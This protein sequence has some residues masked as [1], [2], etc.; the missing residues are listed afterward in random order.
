MAGVGVMFAE[1]IQLLLLALPV[2]WAAWTVTKEEI[3]RELREYCSSRTKI[4]ATVFQRKFYYVWTCEYC[5]SHCVAVLVLA[6]TQF[7]L[8]YDDWRGY[9][10]SGPALVFVANVYM[11]LYSRLRVD[12]RKERATADLVE[13]SPR[14]DIKLSPSESLIKRSS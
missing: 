14:P 5:F 6:L 9:L 7:K 11:S 3:F 4:C 1:V 13:K 12:I 10:V 2:A 8:L